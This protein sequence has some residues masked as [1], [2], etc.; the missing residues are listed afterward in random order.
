M[1]MQEHKNNRKKE[2]IV[3]DLLR[4]NHL[5]FYKKIDQRFEIGVIERIFWWHGSQDHR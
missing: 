5:R 3:N 1:G 4:I 2:T